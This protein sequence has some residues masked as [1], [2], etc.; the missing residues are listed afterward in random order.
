MTPLQALA[1][2]V[3]QLEQAQR[4]VGPTSQNPDIEAYER[5]VNAIQAILV[6]LRYFVERAND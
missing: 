3:A 2:A 5:I 1:N 6:P 4:D